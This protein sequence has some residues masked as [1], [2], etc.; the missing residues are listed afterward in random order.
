MKLEKLLLN[1]LDFTKMDEN[2][3]VY[4]EEDWTMEIACV[5]RKYYVRREANYRGLIKT[6]RLILNNMN[7][8]YEVLHEEFGV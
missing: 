4:E 7:E 3:Y 8:M 6:R 2:I 1:E 5:G